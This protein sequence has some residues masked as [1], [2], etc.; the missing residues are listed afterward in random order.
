MLF[1]DGE[2][3]IYKN[4]PL[5]EV[6]CQL[7]F[8]TIL[9]ISATDPA[10][11]QDKIRV[12]YPMYAAQSDSTSLGTDNPALGQTIFPMFSNQNTTKN[13]SFV[14]A[15]G[16]WK[17]NL[18]NSFIALSSINYQRW[19]EFYARLLD[20]LEVFEEEYSPSFYSRIGLR[21]IDAF[22]KSKL[23][24][25]GTPWT[26]LIS[27]KFLGPLSAEDV[28]ENLV[29]NYG[30]DIE[31]VLDNGVDFMKVHA[32]FGVSIDLPQEKQFIVDSDFYCPSQTEI[33]PAKEKINSLHDYSSKLMRG[34]VL[35]K[36]HDS[37]EPTSI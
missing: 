9:S 37:M 5:I 7:R 20:V 12:A 11:F 36:L 16:Q 22:S 28:D 34:I 3:V 10:A 17:I 26:D 25:E 1:H 15:D 33:M 8:P 35:P 14:S 24:L 13:H 21:Y 19:E 30:M 29:T 32:G 2:R 18:T 23:N 31:T 4:N 6:V 27:S